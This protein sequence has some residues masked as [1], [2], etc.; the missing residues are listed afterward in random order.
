M[1][2]DEK[3]L[4]PYSFVSVSDTHTGNPL[5]AVI[6]KGGIDE[7]QQKA[8]R[9]LEDACE[10]GQLD[11]TCLSV[12]AIETKGHPDE[13]LVLDRLYLSGE[14]KALGYETELVKVRNR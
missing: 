4:E 9:I 8:D 5:G 13:N 2:R 11:P 7:T 1:V 3:S 12:R 14:L 10:T 6:L